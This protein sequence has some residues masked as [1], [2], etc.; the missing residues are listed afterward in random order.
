MEIVV[1]D[2]GTVPYERDDDHDGRDMRF[3]LYQLNIIW[4]SCLQIFTLIYLL[5]QKITKK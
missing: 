1:S 4:D 3:V 5:N 2:T